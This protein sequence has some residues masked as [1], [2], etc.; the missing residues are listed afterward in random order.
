MHFVGKD[1]MHGWHERVGRDIVGDN[2]YPYPAVDDEHTAQI[3]REPGTGSKQNK[4]I[5]E[6]RD[7]QPGMD[8]GCST[9]STL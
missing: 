9:T 2:G 7:A 6:I 8:I 4:V 5:Q 3:Q 1:V